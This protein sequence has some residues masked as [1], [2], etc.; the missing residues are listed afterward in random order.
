V[1]SLALL[2]DKAAT[3]GC[4]PERAAGYGAYDAST[5]LLDPIRWARWCPAR[6]VGQDKGALWPLFELLIGA[7]GN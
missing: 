7:V 2:R 5:S 1:F 6:R 4:F 3:N